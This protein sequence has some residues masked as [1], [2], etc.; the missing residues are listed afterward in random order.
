[1]PLV[2]MGV[3]GSGKSTVAIA[4]AAELGGA[5]LDADD[6]H[7]AANVAK[8]AAGIPLTDDDRMPWLRV[9]GEAMA[10]ETAQDRLAVVACSALR[11]YYRDT[12]RRAGG[13]V[14]FVQLDGSPELL[15]AR[16]NARTD[17]FMPPSLLASQLAALEPLEADEPGVVVSIDAPVDAIVAEASARWADAANSDIL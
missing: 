9:V 4:L 12:L 11:R 17:H 6:F 13:D 10:A 7:P 1:M 16:I 8:M 5:Y 3:A 2:V 15:A 14:F